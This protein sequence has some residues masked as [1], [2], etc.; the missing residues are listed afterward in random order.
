MKRELDPFES[1]L[2][3]KLQGKAS[4][5]EDILWKRLNDELLRSDQQVAPKNRYWILGAAL[6]VFISL[7]TGYYIGVRQEA[8]TQITD[9]TIHS[10]TKLTS[11]KNIVYASRNARAKGTL[12]SVEETRF[13][14]AKPINRTRSVNQIDLNGT[15]SSVKIQNSLSTFDRTQFNSAEM[16]T[17]LPKELVDDQRFT[18]PSIEQAEKNSHLEDAFTLEKLALR[19]APRLLSSTAALTEGSP[20]KKHFPILLSA[21]LGFEPTSINRVQLDRIYGEGTTFASNEKGL[22]ATNV[23]IGFQ[24]KLGRHLELGIGIGSSAL[25]TQ[26]ILQNQVVEIDPLTDNLNFESS[27]SS[28]QIHEDHIHDDPEDQEENELNFEDSTSFHLN[29]QISNSIKSIQ[30]PLSAGFVFNWNNWKVSMKTG[31]IYN[32]ITQANQVLNINGFKAIR[33]N[34][35]SQVVSNSYFHV[36]QLGA[37]YPVSTHFSVLLSPKYSYALKSISK[38]TVLRPNALGLECALKFY[39]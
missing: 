1:K 25:L 30:V 31:L 26:Q 34:L 17:A 39:F 24:A 38:S 10:G 29:Y 11:Q 22:T 14:D 2:K 27:I 19:N 8:S 32:H 6:L 16:N 12:P 33:N 20:Y 5:P 36:I 9:N 3:E 7:G 15:L 21:S 37:E 13:P 23:K 18:P 4:F 35:A 28:F